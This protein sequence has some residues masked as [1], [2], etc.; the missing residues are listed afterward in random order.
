M[1]EVH[2]YSPG[3]EWSRITTFGFGWTLASS[4]RMLVSRRYTAQS[5][6]GGGGPGSWLRA[7]SCSSMIL[8]NGSSSGIPSG[9]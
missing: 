2:N 3:V 6:S 7:A 4:L 8:K 1:L 9:L 5:N